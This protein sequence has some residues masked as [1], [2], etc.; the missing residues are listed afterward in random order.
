M[1]N[2]QPEILLNKADVDRTFSFN[3]TQWAQIAPQMIAPGWKVRSVEH[4]TGTQII[5]FDPANGV[6]L[7]IQPFF[8]TETGLPIMLDIGNYF[9]L[10]MFTSLTEE[11]KVEME[12][13]AQK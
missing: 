13:V 11:L 10:G 6:G 3:K 8:T 2:V 7:S 9:P 4:S 1:T 5:G 12:R